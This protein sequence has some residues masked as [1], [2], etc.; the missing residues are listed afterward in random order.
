MTW[1]PLDAISL[2]ARPVYIVAAPVSVGPP[3]IVTITSAGAFTQP[4]SS[5]RFY[6][7][8]ANSPGLW[9]KGVAG[10]AADFTIDAMTGIFSATAN[11]G[12]GT[13][14]FV[15]TLPLIFTPTDG[16][17]AATQTVTV[18]LTTIAAPST[19]SQSYVS[20]FTGTAGRA[21][22]TLPGWAIDGAPSGIPD[23]P[24][25]DG[26]GG[27]VGTGGHE[28]NSGTWAVVY[29]PTGALAGDRVT[30]TIYKGDADDYNPT[31]FAVAASDYQ[32]GYFFG[33][34]AKAS[35]IDF[36]PGAAYRQGA[37]V[38]SISYGS[39]GINYKADGTADFT[40]QFSLDG[41]TLT[42]TVVG[43][44]TVTATYD[45]T[46][47]TKGQKFGFGGQAPYSA[48]LSPGK[49]VRSI[50]FVR[51]ITQLVLTVVPTYSV[52]NQ[53][54]Y[55][56]A[57]SGAKPTQLRHRFKDSNGAYV[58][59][60][61]VGDTLTN[62]GTTS[63]TITYLATAP[64]GGGL[65]IEVAPLNDTGVI[66]AAASPTYFLA[67][68]Q[69][70]AAGA[71]VRGGSYNSPIIWRKNW[72][73]NCQCDAHSP[74]SGQILIPY[75]AIVG[76]HD[77]DVIPG[78]TWSGAS[79]GITITAQDSVAGTL[80]LT[81]VDGGV[82][83][84]TLNWDGAQ[85]TKFNVIPKA[86][87]TDDVSDVFVPGTADLEY[88]RELDA[89]LINFT[90][91]NS[92]LTFNTMTTPFYKNDIGTGPDLPYQ[93]KVAVHAKKIATQPNYKGSWS[94]IGATRPMEGVGVGS[95]R[96]RAKLE[97][98][99]VGT[100]AKFIIEM[101]NE[102]P[103]NDFPGIL[104]GM[105]DG[106]RGGYYGAA[107]K[108]ALQ[109]ALN[110]YAEANGGPASTYVTTGA[111]ASGDRLMANVYG[112]GNAIYRAKQN[113]PI[114]TPVVNADGTENAFFTRTTINMPTAGRR[115]QLARIKQAM[116]IYKQEFGDARYAAQIGFC[117]MGQAGGSIYDQFADYRA[118]DIAT[119]NAIKYTGHAFY[120][121][122]PDG[123]FNPLSVTP[124]QFEV[125][126]RA[127]FERM[128][129]SVKLA[130]TDS[131]R[132]GKIP[133]FYEG[134]TDPNFKYYKNNPA[135]PYYG[136]YTQWNNYMAS[137][138]GQQMISDAAF[139]MKQTV[140]GIVMV[141]DYAGA[142]PWSL[143]DNFSDT[144]NK[145]CLGWKAGLARTS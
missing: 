37:T 68:V 66:T 98:A 34:Y 23:I 32:N 55:T 127:D 87:D 19:A 3:S 122:P 97:A 45:L 85:P 63:G 28:D 133:A 54:T 29:T 131:L 100:R 11:L 67:N 69:P 6:L 12:D 143:R 74:T 56:A 145:R 84:R 130:V 21:L 121:G 113:A 83:S 78:T 47:K 80:R 4:A 93:A 144:T 139:F 14:Q 94:L 101:F 71:N 50:Q 106:V 124:A 57:W 135:D 52:T 33:F 79:G 30:Y 27:L 18:T 136:Y 39:G 48:A 92:N 109:P 41:N 115:Y 140:P 129:A 25:T 112:V 38:T 96:D 95:V 8:T 120:F 64:S 75:D 15:K 17:A 49:H 123:S 118:W 70:F 60:W 9:S 141:Y 102:Y 22:N 90:P 114:G 76:V 134:L 16:S 89:D 104:R 26:A 99:T 40:F 72:G 137:D 36:S 24:A 42:L 62:T 110:V 117:L 59:P 58:T 81:I 116:D 126:T 10:N 65:T 43:G 51:P 103:W 105:I 73:P 44:S 77:M 107:T 125:A 142:Q 13:V 1:N 7:A 88:I 86:G 119:F 61:M 138:A 91:L 35:S 108:D 128:K 53:A 82:T 2:G 111:V 5:Q 31:H 20:D 46:G 132:M